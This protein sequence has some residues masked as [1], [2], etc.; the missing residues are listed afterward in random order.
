MGREKN[1]LF[2]RHHTNGSGNL[3]YSGGV[4]TVKSGSVLKDVLEHII[5]VI[6]MKNRIGEMGI[7]FQQSPTLQLGYR[8]CILD[9]LNF[10]VLARVGK[11][12][13]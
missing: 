1:V 13:I 2:V 7:T 5:P 4:L 11:K 9:F 12:F 3:G 10:I 6:I 8:H